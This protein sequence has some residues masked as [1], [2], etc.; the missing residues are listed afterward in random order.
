MVAISRETAKQSPEKLQKDKKR[1][2]SLPA[3]LLQIIQAPYL[4]CSLI[5]TSL[6]GE[7]TRVALF[8]EE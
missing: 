4:K 7:S 2:T 3:H 5:L 1:R 6:L 8:E